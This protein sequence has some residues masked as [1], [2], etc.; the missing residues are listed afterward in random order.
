MGSLHLRTN[1]AI[2]CSD[3]SDQS[4]GLTAMSGT[5]LGAESGRNTRLF[6]H[7]PETPSSRRSGST[8][9]PSGPPSH[10]G[11]WFATTL[12]DGTLDGS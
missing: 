7:H 11:S 1:L 12:P 3:M 10:G 9:P 5:P 4:G 6:H 2:L 8:G